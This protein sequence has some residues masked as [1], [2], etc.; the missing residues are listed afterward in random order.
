MTITLYSTH[1]PKCKVIE[2]KLKQAGLA[3][4]EFDDI[5]KIL[6]MGIKTAPMLEV[7]GKLMDFSEANRFLKGVQMSDGCNQCE[8]K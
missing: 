4:T 8:V 3:Y 7:D 1:C 5:D 6:S 2:T